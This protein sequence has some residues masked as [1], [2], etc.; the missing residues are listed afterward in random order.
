M[1]L[2]YCGNLQNSLPTENANM[3]QFIQSFLSLVIIAYVIGCDSGPIDVSTTNPVSNEAVE[4]TKTSNEI[5]ESDAVVGETTETW[6][7]LYAKGNKAGYEHSTITTL[8]T[9]DGEQQVRQTMEQFMWIERFGDTAKL[10]TL[11]SSLESADDR[12]LIEFRTVDR[13]SRDEKVTVGKVDDGMLEI[14]AKTLG[15]TQTS[16]IPWRKETGGFFA[17]EQSLLKRPMK[18]GERRTIRSLQPLLNKVVPTQL[19]ALDY[20]ETPM[21]AGKQRLLKINQKVDLGIAKMEIVIW[22]DKEGEVLKGYLPAPFEMTVYRTTKEIALRPVDEV[23]FTLDDLTVLKV[24]R[25]LKNAHATRQIEYS[26]KISSGDLKGVF[27]EGP[28]QSVEL[29][30]K[31]TASITVRSIRPDDPMMVDSDD[32]PSK[33][34]LQPNGLIQSDDPR[35]VAM[36]QAV[37]PNEKDHWKVAVAMEKF[38]ESSIRDVDFTQALATAA[39]VAKTLRGDCTEH[40]M[41][42]A[43]LCRA[44][45]IPSRVA[46][47]LVYFNSK[48]VGPSFAYHMWTE[49]WIEDRWIPLDAT[50]GRGGIGAAHLKITHSNFKGESAFSAFLPVI[51]VIGRLNLKIAAVTEDD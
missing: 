44:R 22:V 10:S 47:G 25:Q 11:V 26:V 28:S 8:T 17:V 3:S 30:Y 24:D 46:V 29:I 43:A 15:N 4:P 7:V 32:Q 36:S 38:V 21:L 39:E 35:I 33:G 18:L 14:E 19:E 27:A 41:L 42:L 37:L 20:E 23:N 12:R 49:V 13:S 9:P 2:V 48:K 34:D 1:R 16:A 5:D 40:A 45:D 51:Q 31:S 50:L 6:N